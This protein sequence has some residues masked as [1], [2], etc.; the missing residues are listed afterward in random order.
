MNIDVTVFHRGYH[1]DLNET[2]FVGTPSEKAE[3]LVRNTHECLQ[4]AIDESVKPGIKV[5]LSV[6]GFFEG[7]SM[8]I[9]GCAMTMCPIRES[10]KGYQL[11][12]EGIDEIPES[13]SVNHQN[14][15]AN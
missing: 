9:G 6:Q 2:L 1:G 11:N 4:K 8:R 14:V 12:L 5:S 10:T 13:E 3:K 15:G 7:Y